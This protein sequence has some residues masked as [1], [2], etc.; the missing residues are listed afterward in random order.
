MNKDNNY[1]WLKLA[2][3]VAFCALLIYAR[4]EF[5]SSESEFI[6]VDVNNI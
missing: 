5:L 2:G 4:E 6:D 3:A 1:F